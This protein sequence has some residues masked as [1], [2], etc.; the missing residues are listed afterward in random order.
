MDITLRE[1]FIAA[2]ITLLGGS[3]WIM[4]SAWGHAALHALGIQHGGF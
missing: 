3:T 2:G 4:V 1:Q